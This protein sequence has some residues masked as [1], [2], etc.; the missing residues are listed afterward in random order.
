MPALTLQ[1]GAATSVDDSI[2][3]ASPT[4]NGGVFIGLCAA[5][6]RRGL[7]KFDI[8]PPVI[9]ANSTITAATLSLFQSGSGAASAFTATVYSIAAAN[10]AWVEGTKNNAQA[11]AGEPCWNALA[12]DGAG[13]VTTAWGGAAGLATSGVDY[14]ALALGSANGD[15]VDANGTEYAIAL[16]ASRVAGWMTGSN[17]GM[18]IIVS[19][20]CGGLASSDDTTAA[21][22][23]KLVVTYTEP[24]KVLEPG[25]LPL[26]HQTDVF[27][28][29][30]I[31]LRAS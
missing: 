13:G 26:S 22:R 2:T 8:A 15:R 24:D 27:M 29:G 11:G 17:Y 19:A 9:P 23:P 28:T 25:P 10:A 20:N 6:A 30:A 16:T 3:S 4:F 5:T 31:Q 7:L 18:L 1:P 14:E 21:W 12:A